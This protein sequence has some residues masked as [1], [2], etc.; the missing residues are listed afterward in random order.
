MTAL[1]TEISKLLQLS[2]VI[3]SVLGYTH[4]NDIGHSQS[5]LGESGAGLSE[6]LLAQHQGGNLI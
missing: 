4:P 6:R 5:N 2:V 1:H 3:Q